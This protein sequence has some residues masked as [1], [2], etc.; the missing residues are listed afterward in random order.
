MLVMMTP[1]PAITITHI[2]DPCTAPLTHLDWHPTLSSSLGHDTC[3]PFKDV[4]WQVALALLGLMAVSG[5]FRRQPLA[6]LLFLFTNS[7]ATCA[8]GGGVGQVSATRCATQSVLAFCLDSISIM[9][10]LALMLFLRCM[11]D[12]CWS[13]T[14]SLTLKPMLTHPPGNATFDVT[15]RWLRSEAWS[16]E[17]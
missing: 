12:H 3:K 16:R 15:R 8:W 1:V 9:H 5:L 13:L 10:M 6:L 7:L 11:A 14:P 17:W 2:H 4:W